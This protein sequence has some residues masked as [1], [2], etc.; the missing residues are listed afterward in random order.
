MP[1]LSLLYVHNREL[2]YG[3]LGVDL[4]RAVARQGIDVFDD[5]PSP[6]SSDA[7]KFIPHTDGNSAIC[8]HVSWVAT[9]GHYRGHWKGQTTSLLSMWESNLLPEPFRECLDVFD[10][11][12]VPSEQNQELFSRYHS[13]VKYVP[14]G[15]DPTEWFPMKRPT[16]DEDHFTFLISGGGHRKGSD[17]VI[18]AFKKVF[19]SRI[20]DGPAPRLFVHSAKASE[21]PKDDRIH[22]ITGKLTDEEEVALYAMCHVYVQPSRGEGFGLRPLQA[23]AQGM[24]TIATNAHGHAAYGDLLTYPLGFTLQET[25]PQAFHHGP[26]GSWWEPDLDD[27]CEAMEDAYLHYDRAVSRAR[28]NAGVVGREFTWDETARKYLDAIGREN[29]ELPDVAPVEWVEPVAR[30][31]LV[32]V[33]VP[34]PMEVAGVQYMFEPGRDYFEPADVKRVLFDGGHLDLACLPQNMI[35]NADGDGGSPAM[36][37]LE[38]GLTPEQLK[39]IPDY[40]ASAALCPTCHQMLNTNTP[41]L[42]FLES[43]PMPRET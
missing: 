14:L 42:E 36:T 24:P 41:T 10:T 2:G 34:K 33:N 5:L 26:A 17:L 15:I 43:L 25:P 13:N 22:L 29:L 16:L 31:Y 11:I 30:R 12:V 27:L 18:D 21:F 20:P 3:R 38:S 9:P 40:T 1:R 7:H 28:V 32:R 19:D 37:L 4:A 23:M 6:S 39:Q 8:G 35:I